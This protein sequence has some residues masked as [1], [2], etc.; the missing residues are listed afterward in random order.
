MVTANWR[1]CG[2]TFGRWSR[3]PGSTVVCATSAPASRRRSPASSA[4][5]ADPRSRRHL[6]DGPRVSGL[7]A[8]LRPAS[9]CRLLRDPA[10]SN[11]DARRL[12]S[13]AT[14]MPSHCLRGTFPSNGV[15]STD[16]SRESQRH[17]GVPVGAS[18][19]ALSHGVSRTDS[20]L[21]AVRRERSPR[22]AH[23]RRLRPGADPSGQ[24]TL[25]CGELRGGTV[26]PVTRSTRPHSICACRFS[27]GRLFAPPRLP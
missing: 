14:V 2:G 10:K 12:Y 16:L 7:R 24:K 9:S 4:P 26:R 1:G 3:A 19:K 13:A 23:L 8:A 25:C 11:L 20:A 27:R 6:P 21:D 5:T 22:L 18:L 17:R 15:C